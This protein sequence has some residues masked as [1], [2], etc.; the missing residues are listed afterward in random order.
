MGKDF[1]LRKLNELQVKK[2][3]K[4]QISNMFVALENLS[5]S[6]DIDGGLGKH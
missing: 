5:D 2:Q 1:Y 3:Y 6:E 4:I